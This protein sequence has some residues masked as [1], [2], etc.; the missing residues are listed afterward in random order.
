[1]CRGASYADSL[2]F[3]RCIDLWRLALQIRVTRYSILYSD[4]CFT[5]Q[6]LVRLMLDLQDKY[7]DL[8]PNEF[9]FQGVPQFSDVFAVFTLLT[10]NMAGWIFSINRTCENILI[11]SIKF[12][13]ARRLLQIK[14][15][16]RKQ[17]ENFDRV[18]KCVTHLIYLLVETSKT[19]E[20]KE[21]VGKL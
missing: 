7:V 5:A 11:D 13:E 8:Q 3:Q 10:Q 18:L 14:P 1:M 2:R 17:Q 16:H 9:A 6:A 21:M 19:Q 4:T 12:A 15:M 20:E